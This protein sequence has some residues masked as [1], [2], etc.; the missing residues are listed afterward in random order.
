M[1]FGQKNFREID[2]FDLTSF[3]VWTFSNFLARALIIST[4]KCSQKHDGNP[5]APIRKNTQN[6][7]KP[8]Q[9]ETVVLKKIP[10]VTDLMTLK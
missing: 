3:L 10:R 5:L 2:L 1:E 9:N 7:Q 6:D 4:L 8:V